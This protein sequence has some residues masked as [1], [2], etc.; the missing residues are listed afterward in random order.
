MKNSDSL[1]TDP[2]IKKIRQDSNF[3]AIK[4][5]VE[6]DN[7]L[8][9]AQNRIRVLQTHENRNAQK[10]QNQMGLIQKIQQVR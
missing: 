8:K 6:A 3:R 5:L 9:V 10:M 7:S 4:N 2:V 1:E